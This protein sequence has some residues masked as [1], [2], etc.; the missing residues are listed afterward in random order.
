[1]CLEI[2]IFFHQQFT[3]VTLVGHPRAE[4]YNPSVYLSL[5]E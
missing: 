4:P 2:G 1:M 3:K 5:K